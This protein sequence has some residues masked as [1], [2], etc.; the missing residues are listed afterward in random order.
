MRSKIL[1]P[2]FIVVF[3][4]V[5]FEILLRIQKRNL[6]WSE[7]VGRGYT[8]GYNLVRPTW[9]YSWNPDAEFDVDQ[10]DFKYHYKTNHLGI[11]ERETFYTDTGAVRILCL[12]DSYTE[13]FGAPYDSSYPRLLENTM[14]ARGFHNQ[15]YNAGIAASDPF[16]AY[17][18]LKEKLL[19]A[20]PQYVFITFNSSDLTDFVYRGG[21]ERFKPDGTVQGRKGPWYEPLYQYSFV[22]RFFINKVC[23]KINQNLFLTQHEYRSVACP[24]AVHEI[25]IV[26]DSINQFGKKQGFELMVIIQPI[27]AE[28]T[29]QEEYNIFTKNVFSSMQDTLTARHIKVINMWPALEGKI[30]S[31]NKDELSYP[32]DCHY[33]PTGYALFTNTLV[34]SIDEKYPDYWKQ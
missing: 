21:L 34:K 17:I 23:G 29:S 18:L 31:A 7:T 13:G 2:L 28:L 9:F 25:A 12:G 11:R 24:Q 32:N 27:A 30:T 1:Y 19:P 15:V 22:C 10:K 14:N 3:T 20:K 4:L 16:N 5:S 8:S 33:T 26:F 6:V